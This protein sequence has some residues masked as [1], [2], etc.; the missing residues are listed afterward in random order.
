[1]M[2]LWLPACQTLWRR[3]MVRLDC[4]S[5][6]HNDPLGADVRTQVLFPAVTPR[7]RHTNK[8]EEE[9]L[10]RT[11]TAPAWASSH[12]FNGD[13]FCSEPRPFLCHRDD[14]IISLSAGTS[15]LTNLPQGGFSF[16]R[17]EAGSRRRGPDP[18]VYGTIM[19][20]LLILFEELDLQSC[21]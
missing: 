18:Q 14:L 3:P 2:S 12:C 8:T 15:R 19:S 21:S 10:S 5:G 4:R 7:L 17:Q 9:E 6:D 16:Q 13:R 20:T 11:P 1:M